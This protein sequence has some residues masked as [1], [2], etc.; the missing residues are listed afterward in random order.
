MNGSESVMPS[1]VLLQPVA[2]LNRYIMTSEHTKDKTVKFFQEHSYFGLEADNVIV[3]EQHML[4]CF[5]FE[6]QIILA[7]KH[8]V[9]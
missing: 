4:P 9:C 8:K 3:F 7:G 6:G 1:I 5:T 2:V